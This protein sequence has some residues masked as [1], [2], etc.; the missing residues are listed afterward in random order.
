MDVSVSTRVICFIVI[1]VF[2][3]K[4]S[5]NALQNPKCHGF[6]RF[7]AFESIALLLAL[8][9][10]VWYKD[11]F[12]PNQLVSWVFLILS[13]A[14]VL[15]GF[16][17]LKFQGGYEDRKESKENFTFE[18]TT[19]LVDKG[20]YAYIRHPMYSSLL[21]LAW[22]IFMKNPSLFGVIPVL[23]ATASL[24]VTARIEEQENVTFFGPAYE[25]YITRT[26]MFVPFIL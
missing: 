14:I 7:F 13:V 17:L 8:N 3:I 16:L 20:V 4:I 1:S 21:F 19:N 24:V 9:V 10:T 15:S 11:V 18:N 2:F 22:G 23:V 12:S 5:W 6:Y 25:T 26:K